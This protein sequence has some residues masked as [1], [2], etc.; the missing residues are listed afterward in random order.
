VT[1]PGRILVVSPHP[2]DEV[3]GCGGT[4]ARH[5]KHGE[6]VEVALVSKGAPEIFSA[7]SVAA[8]R[9]EMAEAHKALGVSAVHFLDFPAPRLDT[10]AGHLLADRLGQIVRKLQPD[11]V[12]APHWGDLHADHKAVYWASLVATRPARGSRVH[13]LLCYET[14]SETEWGGPS[15]DSAF[16]P[17]VFIDIAEFLDTKLRAMECYRGQLR[18]FPESRSLRSLEALARLRGSTVGL[19][20]A[21]AFVMVR[22][23]VA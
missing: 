12:Y 17:T 18:P 13:R 4:I 3:L 20:A 2:D 15:P 10:V 21:E 8:T 6:R 19:E 14:Q 5:V 11:T 7:E 23:V 22:E 16:S 9:A 1:E